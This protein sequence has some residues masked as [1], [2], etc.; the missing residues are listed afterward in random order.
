MSLRAAGREGGG[1][2]NDQALAGLGGVGDVDLVAGVLAEELNARDG[3][4]D[5]D[6]I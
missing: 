6:L 1:N 2:T 5:F 3:V 4:A